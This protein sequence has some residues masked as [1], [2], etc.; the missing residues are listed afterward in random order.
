MA[1]LS[2][3]KTGGG[4]TPFGGRVEAACAMKEKKEREGKRLKTFSIGKKG[5][6]ESEKGRKG[7]C[8]TTLCGEARLRK[9][10]NIFIPLQWRKGEKKGPR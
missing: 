10:R 6:K 4:V 8:C 9:V 3:W 1:K 2:P 7:L 5:E